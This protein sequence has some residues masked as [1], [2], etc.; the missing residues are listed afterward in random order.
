MS[1]VPRCSVCDAR[2]DAYGRDGT[3]CAR[4]SRPCPD[5]GGVIGFCSH[6]LPDA[7]WLIEVTHPELLPENRHRWVA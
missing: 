3:R 6:E 1:A 4:C 5:C 2:L 7:S